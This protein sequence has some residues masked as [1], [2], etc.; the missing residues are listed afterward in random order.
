MT[1]T[2]HM[3]CPFCSPVP[4]DIKLRNELCYAREDAFPVSP[5][6]T[7]IV[8]FRHVADFFELKEDEVKAMLEL[9]WRVRDRALEALKPGGFNV[10]VNAGEVAG[11]TV[12]HVHLHL[13]PRFKGDV[14]DPRSGVRW[15]I[16]TKARYW[17]G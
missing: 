17:P 13:I 11:Q 7:L 15:I 16:P 3:K 12:M 5:G 2:H 4:S 6:H 10:G 14:A 1:P 9:L 8:P